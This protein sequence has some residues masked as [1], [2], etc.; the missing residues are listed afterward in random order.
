M[1][2]FRN[3]PHC[4]LSRPGGEAFAPCSYLIV[5]NPHVPLS[6]HCY[7]DSGSIVSS[8]FVQATWVEGA[9]EALIPPSVSNP[10][11][12]AGAGANGGGGGGGAGAGAGAGKGGGQGSWRKIG[13]AWRRVGGRGN[14]GRGGGG[15]TGN[16]ARA[17]E[18]KVG[19]ST[20]SEADIDAPLPRV[21]CE[22]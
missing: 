4:R 22:R 5:R 3:L 13:G 2:F 9:V 17:E 7:V 20:M 21:D 6:C 14:G 1:I 8:L 11:G 10:G 12:G 16:D 19:G 15:G 18:E